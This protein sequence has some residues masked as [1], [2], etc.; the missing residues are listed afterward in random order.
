LWGLYCKCPDAQFIRSF[1]SN[2]KTSKISVLNEGKIKGIIKATSNEPQGGHA[3]HHSHPISDDATT[4]ATTFSSSITSLTPG[5]TASSSTDALIKYN[6]NFQNALEKHREDILCLIRKCTTSGKPAIPTKMIGKVRK[7]N[8]ATIKSI[9]KEASR[10]GGKELT[11]KKMKELGAQA[12][13]EA[14]A[15][16][17]A[18]MDQNNK[19]EQEELPLMNEQ[20]QPPVPTYPGL[21]APELVPGFSVMQMELDGN[22]FYHSVS[23]QLF[24]DKGA[25]HVIVCHQ[26]NNHIRRNGEEF[27]NFLLLNDSNLELT[28]L[29][30]YINQMGQDGA[31]AGHLEIYVAA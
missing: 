8:L 2:S 12:E 19:M 22:C 23:D 6:T 30:K 21:W 31:W 18:K 24:G 25:G 3:F 29:R 16:F 1:K 28:D 7:A 9:K 4:A 10:H 14:T 15:I 27:K 20:P 13:K 5:T 26:I 17:V 11:T